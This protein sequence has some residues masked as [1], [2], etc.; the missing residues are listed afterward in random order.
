MND[1]QPPEESLMAH[2]LELRTR[3]LKSVLALMAVFLA[4]LPFANELYAWL[5]KPLLAKLPSGGQL[6][7]IDVASPFFTPIKLAFF[8][9]LM[10]VMPVLLYQA[11]A[12]VAPGLYRHEKKLAK[13]L[14]VTAVLLF[15]TG[16]AFAYYLVLPTVFGFLTAVTPAG[17]AMMTDI[18][19]YLDF[20]LVLFFAFGASFELPVAVVVLVL[21]GWV[22]PAQLREA[23][24]YVIVGVF[25][26]AA[27]ITP[28]DVVSQLM[29][30][31]PMCL[32]YEIGILAGQLL[33][34]KPAA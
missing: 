3:L 31:I 24:G 5:A 15:Y 4:L 32:L 16:C 1:G 10:V 12:F 20:V 9:A 8:V 26:L 28:P 23:R 22:T 19:R 13:P 2:L 34:P 11:W 7:A 6:V 33:R 14:L 30:A 27:V 29:L 18:G 17:V 21:L 25:I